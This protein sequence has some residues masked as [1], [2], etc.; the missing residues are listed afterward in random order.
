MLATEAQSTQGFSPQVP[1]DKESTKPEQEVSHDATKAEIKSWNKKV[2]D[3]REFFKDQFDQ[4]VEDMNFVYG[5]Q[6][7]EQNSLSKEKRYM[8][9]ITLRNRRNKVATLY[10]RNPETEFKRVNR[11]DYAMWDGK[12]ET[13]LTCLQRLQMNPMD[14]ESAAM[15]QDYMH[16]E[17]FKEQ[18][19]RVGKTL[20]CTYRY[21]I[22][23][24]TPDFKTLLKQHVVATAVDCGV[25]YLRLNYER[26][27]KGYLPTANQIAPISQRMK[28]VV[29]MV[30]Q[31]EASKD[32][33]SSK[34]ERVRILMESI[35]ESLQARDE[36][37]EFQ[38]KLCF[39]A[40]SVMSI[41]PDPDTKALQGW[42][43]TKW[44]CQEYLYTLD[45]VNSFYELTGTENE[46]KAG[47]ALKIYAEDGSELIKQ[48]KPV[49][50][51]NS[52]NAKQ[53]M[54]KVREMFDATSKMRFV[55]CDGHDKYLEYPTQIT[56]ETTVFFP[57]FALTFNETTVEKGCKASIYPP[58]DIRIMR[59]PQKEWNRSRNAFRNHRRANTPLYVAAKGTLT[60]GDKDEF[61]AADESDIL[62][63]EGL[64]PGADI[65]GKI[66]QVNKVALDP[67]L[68]GTEAM[69]ED[70]QLTTG[71]QQADLGPAQPNVTATNSSIAA[72]AKMSVTSADVDALDD[73]QTLVAFTAGEMILR[74]FSIET[75][76]R[77]CGPGTVFP[78]PEMVEDFCNQ[79]YLQAVSASSGR[80]NQ[81][82][83][84]SKAQILVPLLQSYNANPQAVIRY[85]C[86]VLDERI[87]P[88]EFFPIPGMPMIGAQSMGIPQQPQPQQQ[89]MNGA[90]VPQPPNPQNV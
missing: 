55:I 65:N 71:A 57:I 11:L 54:V 77:I 43:G 89:L 29:Q 21:Q 74:G 27:D 25:G 53:T 86:K 38:E 62:E 18:L 78:P 5:L 75:I 4:M 66:Q 83:E 33:N 23:K 31:I 58:S 34:V 7:E 70:I 1:E 73:F 82:I 67:R 9:N 3:A 28:D 20:D 84:Q 41:I 2:D 90:P 42:V 15:L 79:V 51:S 81:A 35:Q 16:G 72:Q 59:M 61:L 37:R 24:Q 6:W 8:A 45:F 40:P 52:L 10:A 64:P 22:N 68:Y 50:G 19:D 44:L 56:P 85:V 32:E 30:E 47:G 80:P 60:E 48:N 36:Q 26:L 63:L 17:E 69:A 76:Q 13:L 12:E 39:E 87:D 14:M 49:D 46:V 88:T